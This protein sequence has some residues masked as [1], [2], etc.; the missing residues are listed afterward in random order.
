VRSSGARQ[1][2]RAGAGAGRYALP[3]SDAAGLSRSAPG[4]RR[5][6]SRRPVRLTRPLE[7]AYRD[8]RGGPFHPFT[9]EATLSLLG[10]RELGAR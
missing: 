7:R 3:T 10:A 6:A 4:S 5:T 8:V 9:P 1:T 2:G